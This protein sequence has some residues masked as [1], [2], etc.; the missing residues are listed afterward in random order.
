[1][2]VTVGFYVLL[3]SVFHFCKSHHQKLIV[4]QQITVNKNNNNINI[5]NYPL[6]EYKGVVSVRMV[7]PTYVIV[8][9]LKLNLLQVYAERFKASLICIT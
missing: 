3:Q 5:T 9:G 6:L 7:R 2:S 4:N 1:V 8:K